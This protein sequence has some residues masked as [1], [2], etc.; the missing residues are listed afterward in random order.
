MAEPIH[1]PDA[2]A[3]HRAAA[4]QTFETDIGSVLE[5]QAVN[6]TPPLPPNTAPVRPGSH[7]AAAARRLGCEDE[8]D[9][10]IEARYGEGW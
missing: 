2:L 5:V 1:D 8:W 4:A 10:A 7:N 3:R 9:N 6:P